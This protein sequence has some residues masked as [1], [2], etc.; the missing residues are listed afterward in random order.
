M[1]TPQLKAWIFR[2]N[3]IDAIIWWQGGYTLE[4]HFSLRADAYV[5][6]YGGLMCTRRRPIKQELSFLRGDYSLEEVSFSP[7]NP[8]HSGGKISKLHWFDSKSCLKLISE[9]PSVCA[10]LGRW[11]IEDLPAGNRAFTKCKQNMY[12]YGRK[13]RSE[14]RAPQ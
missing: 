7:A 11:S 4:S 10:E 13:N 3:C 1:L 14:S 9:K 6:F 12:T 5:C 8:L 2:L